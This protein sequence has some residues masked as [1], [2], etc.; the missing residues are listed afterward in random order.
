MTNSLLVVQ[1]EPVIIINGV[2]Y[3][4]KYKAE[5]FAHLKAKTLEERA[6]RKGQSRSAMQTLDGEAIV[7]LDDSDDGN[8]QGG[9]AVQAI[10]DGELIHTLCEYYEK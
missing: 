3:P 8:L 7:W 1:S 6:L 4:G 9:F 5:V 2:E 10:E